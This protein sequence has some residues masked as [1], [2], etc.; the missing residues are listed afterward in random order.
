MR[1]AAAIKLRE[2]TGAYSN[3]AVPTN[4][5]TVGTSNVWLDLW[6][7]MLRTQTLRMLYANSMPMAMSFAV[8]ALP[9]MLVTNATANMLE[10][11]ENLFGDS[12]TNTAKILRVTRPMV[13]HYRGG[14]EPSI[15]NK[16][17][18]Q[19]LAELASELS[20][21]VSEPLKGEL[22]KQ[23]PEGRTLLEFLSDEKL[24]IAVLRQILHRTV[25]TRDHMMRNNLAIAL[26]QGESIEARSDIVHERQAEGKPIYI[27]DSN[28]PG[29]LIQL[30]PDGTRIRG[31][32]VKRKFV[33][34][35]E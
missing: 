10:A 24:D 3:D 34:D 2:Q 21:E 22:K 32:M 12:A 7:E 23:Q 8:Q 16:R 29:K 31:R 4:S 30:L 13:Y 17:R 27:G 28:A 18:L 5:Y 9:M 26:A 19:T 14:M 35:E 6:N 15:E 33:P 11:V 1:Y 25:S 20:A